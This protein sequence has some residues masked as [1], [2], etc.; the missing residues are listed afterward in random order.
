MTHDPEAA[1]LGQGGHPTPVAIVGAGTAGSVLAL[2]LASRGIRSVLIERQP[3]ADTH[4]RGHVW[5]AR[6]MEVI[7]SIDAELAEALREISS[8]PLKLRYITWCTSLAGVDLGRCVPIGNDPVHTARLLGSGPC[9]PLHLSQNVTDPILRQRVAGSERIEFLAGYELEA[10]SQDD[11]GCVLTLRE[12][13]SG[14]RVRRTARFVAG[15]DGAQSTVR[16]LLG[17][18]SAETPLQAVAQIHFRARLDR[19]T[20]SRPSPLYWI[21]NPRVAGT[22]T[23]HT[24]DDEDWVLSTAVLPDIEPAGEMPAARA[25]ALVR[26]AI[27]DDSIDVKVQSVRPWAMALRRAET[28]RVGRVMLL[29][30]AAAG[31]S[32]IGGFGMNHGIEDAA[33]L[34]W[35]L[36]ILLGGF[37]RGDLAQGLLSSYAAE[38]TASADAHARRTLQL[39]ELSDEVLRAAGVEPGGFKTLSALSRSAWVGMLP[40]RV[41]RGLFRAVTG[42]GLK[43]LG[44]LAGAE[45]GGAEARAKVRRAIDKQ[46]EVFVTLGTDLGYA[47]SGGFVCR[48]P[49]P[50]PQSP[51]AGAEYWPSTSPGSLVPHLWSERDGESLSTRDLAR[52]APMTLLVNEKERVRWQAALSQLHSDWGI[53]VACPLVGSGDAAQFR[54]NPSAFAAALEI[55]ESGAV[56]LRGDGIAAWRSRRQCADPRAALRDVV[57]RLVSQ[58]V[59]TIITTITTSAASAAHLTKERQ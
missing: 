8:A 49:H 34:A 11:D 14:R 48:E 32:A 44:H 45:P 24:A 22:L 1:P 39:S 33:S 52:R 53:E 47:H 50:H 56:L 19:L 54:V 26:A 12:L 35:R 40:R 27:G 38:R 28:C 42:A 6:A 10:L 36:Q 37:V 30:D 3:D 41:A 46:R 59:T 55:D 51:H 4:P 43:P 16:R 29:G 2:L 13:R 15:A 17:V 58:S 21:L 20:T 18:R 57:T 31:F 7:R 5:S 9:R 25:L 23:A